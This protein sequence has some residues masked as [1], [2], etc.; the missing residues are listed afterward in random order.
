MIFRN[1]FL[2]TLKDASLVSFDTSSFSGTLRKGLQMQVNYKDRFGNNFL[3]HARMYYNGHDFLSFY[4]SGP[5]SHSTEI[6]L[7]KNQFFDSITL[8]P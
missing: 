3:M 8:T 7:Y 4:I 2:L 6:N 1:I 5:Q